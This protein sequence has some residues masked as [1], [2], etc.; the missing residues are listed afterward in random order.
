MIFLS[1]GHHQND[2]GA[3]GNGY[4]EFEVCAS[5]RDSVAQEIIRRGG[6]VILDK[7]YETLS[8]YL[9]RIKPGSGSVVCDIHFNS[10]LDPTATGTEVFFA[11]NPESKYIA[12]ELSKANAEILGII[13][14]GAKLESKSNRGHLAVLHTKAGISVLPEIC[15]ISNPYDMEAFFKNRESLVHAYACILM[16]ADGMKE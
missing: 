14:R 1:G 16:H 4:N 2:P 6:S 7:D 13:N 11:D 8:G 5:F 3:S 9:N 15:F 12:I 10:V